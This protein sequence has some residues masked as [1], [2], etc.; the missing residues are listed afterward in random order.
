MIGVLFSA[1][2]AGFRSS[3][4]SLDND[5]TSKISSICN[6]ASMFGAISLPY[7][8]GSY[9]KR[10]TVNEWSNVFQMAAILNFIAAF[11]YLI[12]GSMNAKYCNINKLNIVSF[13]TTSKQRDNREN[14]QLL[15][16]CD[17][18]EDL[19]SFLSETA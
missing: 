13:S 16:N 18:I 7:V 11:I 14:D 19:L 6:V 2:V 17:S 3:M 4:I 12:F 5:Y 15:N 1:N 8:V 10:G 9:I